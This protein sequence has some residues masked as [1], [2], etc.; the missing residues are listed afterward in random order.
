ML[1]FWNSNHG[2]QG[3]LEDGAI[4]ETFSSAHGHN[5][6]QSLWRAVL[7]QQILDA[8]SEPRTNAKYNADLALKRTADAWLRLSNPDFRI[9]C[10]L[11]GLAPDRIAELINK[12]RSRGFSEKDFR[13]EQKRAMATLYLHGVNPKDIAANLGTSYPSTRVWLHTHRHE[14]WKY[15][16]PT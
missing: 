15:T 12:A 7:L 10:E 6:E 4:D 1:R 16:E 9:V 14:L 13:R 11:A 2:V 8:R 3:V 5:G